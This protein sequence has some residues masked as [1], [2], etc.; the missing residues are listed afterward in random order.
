MIVRALYRLLLWIGFPL[1]FLYLL[2]RSRK[3]PEYRH[4]ERPD[5]TRIEVQVR[6]AKEA[7]TEFSTLTPLQVWGASGWTRE[8]A[9]K[10]LEQHID[11]HPAGSTYRLT[12]REAALRWMCRQY[13]AHLVDLAADLGGWE[14]L[15]LTLR[16][17]V[18]QARH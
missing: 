2:K 8:L 5:W 6:P 11:P 14:C 15:G 13:G 7:K 4:L 9:S 16:E 12:E 3:Q 18:K 10:V 1:I 17:M